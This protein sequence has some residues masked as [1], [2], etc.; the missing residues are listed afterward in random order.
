ME[1]RLNELA[2]THNEAAGRF[3]AQVGAELALIEYRR[4]GKFIIFTHTEVPKAL[5]GRGIAGRLAQVALDYARA[6]HLTVIPLCP[7]VSAYLRQHSE[8]QDI[9][10]PSY[11]NTR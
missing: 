5:E 9:V 6:Q 8:Y 10:H 1:G 7:Y 2:V 4:R 11:R 3:E